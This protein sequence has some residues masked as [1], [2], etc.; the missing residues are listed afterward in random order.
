MAFKKVYEDNIRREKR[1]QE[2]F[3]NNAKKPCCENCLY[4]RKK[5]SSSGICEFLKVYNN[6]PL[7]QVGSGQYCNGFSPSS[8]SSPLLW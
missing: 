7:R 6:G 2:N 8:F 1:I 4:Y 3:T 5:T